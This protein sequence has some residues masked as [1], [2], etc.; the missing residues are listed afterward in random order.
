[1]K[2][3]NELPGTLPRDALNWVAAKQELI[4]N[5]GMWGLMAEDIAAS[6]PD[7]LRKGGYAAFR[8]EELRHFEFATRKPATQVGVEPY[9]KNRTDLYGRYTANLEN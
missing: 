2:L 9:R 7:Q 5:E 4:E 8:G 3:F 6:T 1:M